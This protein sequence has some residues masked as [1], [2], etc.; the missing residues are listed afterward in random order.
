VHLENL[1]EAISSFCGNLF[2]ILLAIYLEILGS[3]AVQK[4]LELVNFWINVL[5]FV[6]QSLND[7]WFVA[8]VDLKELDFCV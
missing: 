2:L 8:K 7:L 4:L 1:N 6:L 3:L 5:V